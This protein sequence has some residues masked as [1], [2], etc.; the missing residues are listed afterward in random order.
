VVSLLFHQACEARRWRRFAVPSLV[1]CVVVVCGVSIAPLHLA[2]GER[3][4]T[5]RRIRDEA[6]LALVV[7]IRDER[8]LQSLCFKNPD[9]L[10]AVVP[11]VREKRLSMFSPD[12]ANKVGESIRASFEI[13]EAPLYHGQFERAYPLGGEDDPGRT[14]LRL[15]G[16]AWDPAAERPPPLVLL[17]DDADTIRGVARPVNSR[18]KLLAS[19][20]DKAS[21]GSGW[22][23]FAKCE[24]GCRLRAYA[25]SA[26][27]SSAYRLPGVYVK[28]K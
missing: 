14:E 15:E 28:R 13:Y 22:I 3:A 6:A 17:V 21:T 23:G 4:V 16:W 2:G 12:W 7:G 11:M 25:V 24:A 26:D 8:Y 20:E 5:A 19:A 9:K 27:E 18:K 10:A 1:C